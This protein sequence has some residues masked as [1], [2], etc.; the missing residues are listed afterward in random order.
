MTYFGTGDNH[1]QM[2]ARAMEA[3]NVFLEIL[4]IFGFVG[5]VYFAFTTYKTLRWI[6][7]FNKSYSIHFIVS[8]ISY[9]LVIS[10]HP[11]YTGV[12]VFQSICIQSILFQISSEWEVNR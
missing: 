4:L 5:L 9:L 8:I 10:M 6:F 11:F 1:V 7:R 2:M 12:Y 3:H